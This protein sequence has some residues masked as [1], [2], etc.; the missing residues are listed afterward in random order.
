MRLEKRE[1]TPRWLQAAAPL[2]SLCLA[3]AAVSALF[4]ASGV[5]PAEAVKVIF[6]SS[7]GSSYGLSE[8]VVKATPLLLMGEGLVLSFTAGV[9]NIGCEGQLL[10]GAVAATWVALYSG[11]GGV[12]GLLLM[13]VA[14]AAAGAAWALIPA[15][16]KAKMDAN[17][18][19]VTLMLNYVAE[20]VVEHLIYGPWRGASEWGF[21]YTDEFPRWAQLPTLGATRIHIPTLALAL[22]SVPLVYWVLS[23]SKLGFEL[24]V[25]G[26]SESAAE[27]AGV[28]KARVVLA[29]LC[30][31][32]MLAGLAGVGEVAGIHHRLRYPRGVSCGY[33]YTAIIVAWL[34]RLNPVLT[35]LSALFLGS[36]LVGGDAIQVKLGLPRGVVDV[37]NGMILLSLLV[38]EVVSRYRV[39]R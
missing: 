39:V 14:G 6:A 3:F 34:G 17:E 9:W 30:V 20:K 10:A 25:Y 11:L 23:R 38:G 26:S 19:I 12:P 8:T 5:S 33:G 32:G 36:L 13:F 31:S 29:C 27:Y 2:G 35:V 4:A 18:V 28:S 1:S 15:A 22:A 37:F 21:P 24:K 16:L 7:L